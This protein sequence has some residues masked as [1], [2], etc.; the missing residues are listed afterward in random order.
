MFPATLD[1]SAFGTLP[2]SYVPWRKMWVHEEKDHMKF[3]T[4]DGV[5]YG[6]V[7]FAHKGRLDGFFLFESPEKGVRVAM[8]NDGVWFI[9]SVGYHYYYSRPNYDTIIRNGREPKQKTMLPITM[10]VG[11]WGEPK[12]QL[13]N[14]QLD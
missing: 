9:D 10:E 1:I 5:R 14:R 7:A 3:V 13:L 4:I 6:V 12:T 8:Q 2:T 11:V